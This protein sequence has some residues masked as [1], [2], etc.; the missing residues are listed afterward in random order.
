MNTDQFIMK[1]GELATRTVT[2]IETIRCYTVQA[3][4]QAKV[5]TASNHRASR[6]ESLHEH[7][8]HPDPALSSQGAQRDSRGCD[9]TGRDRQYFFAGLGEPGRAR[10]KYPKFPG[11]AEQ[12]DTHYLPSLF[13]QW[14]HRRPPQFGFV[15]ADQEFRPH[16]CR[17]ARSCPSSTAAVPESKLSRWLAALVIL[18]TALV[19]GCATLPYAQPRPASYAIED[20]SPTSLGKLARQSA[21]GAAS[22]MSGFR[23]LP[24]A[25]FALEARIALI[26]HAERT[27]DMQYYLIRNDDIGLLLLKELRDAAARGVRVR[28]LVDDLYLG[29]EDELFFALSSFANV[30]VRIFNPLPSRA[31]TLAIRLASSIFEL[32]RINHRMHNKL[33]VADN[34]FSV[35]GG[36]NIANEYFMK[37]TAANFIDLDVLASGP[38]VREMSRSFDLF[39]NSDQ[40]WN[41]RELAQ[42]PWSTS[43]A[44]RRFDKIAGTAAPYVP[45]N[46]SDVFG[47]APVGQQLAQGHVDCHWAHAR[48][49]ADD[50]GKLGLRHDLA[51]RGSVSEAAFEVLSHSLH[52][53]MILSPYFVPGPAGMSVLEQLV[54]EGRKVTVI[55]NSLGSTDEPLTYAGYERYRA[56]MLKIGVSIF[57]MAPEGTS[58]TKRFGNFGGSISRLHAK[59]ALVDSSHIF[60]GSM[61][62][63]H[64]SAAINT[65]LGLLVDS[66]EMVKEFDELLVAEHIDLGYRLQLSANG[67]G[68]QW[69]GHGEG[70]RYVVYEDVPGSFLWLRVK[71][72]LLFPLLGE[73]LL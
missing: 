53:V 27:I 17:E 18:A 22:G 48:F 15:E 12:A 21:A 45:L 68:V 57:E 44:Q 64:R 46:A 70:G 36:R 59:V 34:S 1:I 49:Y 31:S 62:L 72:W 14:M 8:V 66:V 69:V 24:E 10:S 47:R 13:P 4:S 67:Q 43:E 33:L 23:L 60:I 50:P 6:E 63:D 51:Y 9:S 7:A 29:G 38:V 65:E 52:R 39:W 20:S 71:N 26:R 25:A 32:L 5:R 73:E 28:L 37:D 3:L 54:D 19:G 16:G 61:N 35:S 42:L 55:T 56:A 41:M 40:V 2:T 30:E 11:G 58:R